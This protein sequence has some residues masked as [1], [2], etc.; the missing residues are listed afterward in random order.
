MK[1]STPRYPALF[2]VNTRVRLPELAAA[3]GRRATLDDITDVELDRLGAD[4]FDLVWF[5]GVWP[6]GE[7]ARRVS[8]SNPLMW[9]GLY[10]DLP[11]WGYHV[12]AVEPLP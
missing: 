1:A 4:G 10:L 9:P 8:R 11:A 7:A 6:T 2:Q 3:L 12:F 5:L